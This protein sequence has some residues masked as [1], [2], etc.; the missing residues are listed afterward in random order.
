MQCTG[1]RWVISA[2]CC[3]KWIKYKRRRG[4]HLKTCWCHQ[5]HYMELGCC[6][7][8]GV[9]QQCVVSLLPWGRTARKS[10]RGVRVSSCKGEPAEIPP[11]ILHIA[12]MTRIQHH[13]FWEALIKF[14]VCYFCRYHK[15]AGPH[16]FIF[17]CTHPAAADF[18]LLIFVKEWN[19][20]LVFFC[21]ANLSDILSHLTTVYMRCCRN[22]PAWWLTTYTM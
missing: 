19:N 16:H 10:E 1:N 20:V 18:A 7:G 14:S 5:T 8:W 13:R 11:R 2:S 6:L 9:I 4:T 15:V 17:S 21:F 22:L 12:C 3:P